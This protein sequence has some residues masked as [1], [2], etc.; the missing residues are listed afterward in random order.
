MANQVRISTD[1]TPGYAENPVWSDP[2]FLY[3]Y[4]AVPQK[5]AMGNA[6]DYPGLFLTAIGSNIA[7]QRYVPF[8]N[9]GAVSSWYLEM[10]QLNNEIDISTVGDVVLHLY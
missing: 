4:A 2:R 8:E 10:R 5:I 9:A 3:N 6:Q 7:D 1:T